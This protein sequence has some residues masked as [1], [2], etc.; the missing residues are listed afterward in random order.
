MECRLPVGAL[1]APPP[2]QVMSDTD[3]NEA[4]DPNR[5]WEQRLTDAYTLGSV[6]W[7]G[8]GE[9]FNRWMYAVRKRVFSRVARESIDDLSDM[10]V[11]D[12]GSG[13]GFYL[14]AWRELGVRDLSGSDL[15]STAVTGLR[16]AFADI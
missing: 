4:F 2:P 9:S 6:G 7:I 12:V 11:L 5:Y 14:N 10:R 16:T 8:L 3:I 15:T 13:T 1:Q